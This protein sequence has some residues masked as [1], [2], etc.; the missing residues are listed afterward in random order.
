MDEGY[1]P[2]AV[3]EYLMTIINSNFEEWRAENPGAPIEGFKFTTE[4]MS[5]SGILFDIDKLRDV[6]TE[7]LLRTPAGE[8]ADFLVQWARRAMPE[9]AE[10]LAADTA[11]LEK[12]LDIGRGGPKP[13]KDLAY[14]TQIMSHISYFYDSAFQLEA[15]LSDP[16]LPEN[17]IPQDAA[18]LLRAYIESYAHVDAQPPW[19]EKVR[20]L[21]EANG[22]AAKPKDY[23][24]NPAAYK[25]HVGDVSA[26]I[27]LALTGRANSPD[28]WEIQQILGEA[29]TIERLRRAAELIAR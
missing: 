29:R 5:H 28:L 15:G 12:I 11:Y 10:C 22:Y 20:A 24:K 26:V 27:R 23:K 18:R 2:L 19:F 8:L 9:A 3:R 21:S 17:V 6:S 1:H 4:K 13:R 16:G 7:V 14:G 25:G